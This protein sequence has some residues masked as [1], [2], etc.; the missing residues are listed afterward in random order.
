L[1]HSFGEN[2]NFWMSYADLLTKFKDIQ[3]TRLF[4]QPW[5]IAQKWISLTIPWKVDYHKTRFS[6]K[7]NK[8]AP[9]VVVLSQVSRIQSAL[10]RTSAE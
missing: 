6:F 4:E 10:K 5:K 7:M 2:G 1:E 3:Q 9:V 8:K